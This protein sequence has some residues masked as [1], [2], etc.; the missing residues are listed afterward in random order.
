MRSTDMFIDIFLIFLFFQQHTKH[1]LGKSLQE[2]WPGSP[3]LCP[4]LPAAPWGTQAPEQWAAAP[5]PGYKPRAQTQHQL[6]FLSPNC[7]ELPGNFL[8]KQKDSN[9]HSGFPPLHLLWV[10]KTTPSGQ[11][12]KKIST[13]GAPC[14]FL[15]DLHP[16]LA[17]GIK[18][19]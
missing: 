11:F 10:Y 7:L 17:Q 19:Y 6:H 5:S 14:Y 13:M 15:M 2:L 4:E 3:Q 1:A 9:A 12:G 16:R 8:W 18:Y